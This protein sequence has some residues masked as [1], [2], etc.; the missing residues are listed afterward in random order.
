VLFA[1]LKAYAAEDTL[2]YLDVPEV[3][4]AAIALAKRYNMNAVFETAACT[5]VKALICR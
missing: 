2:L 1:A 5:P 3:S 4:P